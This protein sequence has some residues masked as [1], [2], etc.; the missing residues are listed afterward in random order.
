[1]IRKVPHETDVLDEA[2]MRTKVYGGWMVTQCIIG[3]KG[4]KCMSSIFVP[5]GEHQWQIVR[6]T[7][8]AEV[9]V[10]TPIHK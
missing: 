3:E 10:K 9:P 1:M 4:V 5:D 2:M 6:P 7:I 8:E